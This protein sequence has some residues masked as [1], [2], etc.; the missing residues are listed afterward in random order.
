MLVELPLESSPEGVIFDPKEKGKKLSPFGDW[1]LN[2]WGNTIGWEW[3]IVT[4]GGR[5]ALEHPHRTISCLRTGDGTWGDFT[6]EFDIRQLKPLGA[7]SMDQLF[8]T[9]G[10]AGVMFRYQTFRQSYGLFLEN[11]DRVVL[12]RRDDDNWIPLGV[13]E[14]EIDR[15][16]Y[17]RF[18]VECKGENIRCWMD[19]E[20]LFDVKD[21][22]FRQG[23]VAIYSNVLARFGSCRVTTDDEGRAEIANYISAEKRAVSKAVEGLAKPVLWKRIPHPKIVKYPNGRMTFDMLDGKLQGFVTSTKDPEYAREGETALILV[24]LEGNVRW[25]RECYKAAQTGIWDIDGDGEREVIL[26]DGPTLKTLDIKTGEVKRE[27]RTPPC[28]ELGNRGGRENDKPYISPWKMYPAN[29]RGLGKGRDFILMDY[30]TAFWVIN[31]N[32]ELEWKQYREHGHDLRAYDVDGDGRDEV[33]SGWEMFD[34]D[35]R[36]MW[37]V[38]GQEYLMYTYDH[39]DHLEI[40]EFDGNPDNGVEIGMTAG[41]SGFVLMDRSGKIRAQHFVGHAQGL[42]VGQFRPDLPGKQFL[43]GCLWG[44]QGIR[45]LFSGTGEKL[46]TIEPDNHGAYDI[47]LRWAPDR[48]Y[49]LVVSTPKAAGLYDGYGRMLLPFPEGAE[50]N[51][52]DRALRVGDQTGN[53]LDDFA[54]RTED[55]LLVYT[56]G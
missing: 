26:Y 29:L 51:I 45:T 40:G 44:N 43:V 22:A 24:D 52:F 48:D 16:K 33:L 5:K 55:A 35:G 25:A 2:T 12:Y 49:F 15:A 32:L 6:I 46:W 42:C 11:Q 34:H 21:D 9:D 50:D 10:R 7:S 28:N 31:E 30:Y 38:P 19:G 18:K 3:V 13:R 36:E 14:M 41:N 23:M 53:G 56:Q 39:P 47:P 37:S 17:Y 8:T 4:D 20:P 1:T 27:G 54:V